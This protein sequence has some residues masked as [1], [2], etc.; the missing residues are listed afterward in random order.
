LSHVKLGVG[1]IRQEADSAAIW[2][3]AGGWVGSGVSE[4]LGAFV[5]SLATMCRNHDDRAVR[6]DRRCLRSRR[7]TIDG[8]SRRVDHNFGVSAVGK[9]AF[10]PGSILQPHWSKSRDVLR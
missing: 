3:P 2:L 1:V 10:F 9:K 6:P 5:A 8:M 7:W 4:A